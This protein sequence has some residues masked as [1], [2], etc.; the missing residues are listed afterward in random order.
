MSVRLAIAEADLSTLN[1][2]E[3]CRDH[4]ISR[5]RF[6]VLRRRFE[7]EG[8][9][10]L[11]ARS[12]APKRVANRTSAAIEDAIVAKRKELEDGGL[13]HGPATLWWHLS[14]E[15]GVEVV[16]SEATIWRVLVRRGFIDHDPTK[17]PNRRW[18]RFAAERA[19]ECWQLD[20]THWQLADNTP[21]EII[22][23]L[24]DCSRCAINSVAVVTCTAN[25]T[26]AA[27][28]DSAAVWGLPE[29]L[30]RDNAA[31]FKALDDALAGLG[32]QGRHSRPYHPQTCGKVE[33]FH[34]TLKKH[35]A[36]C[37]PYNSLEALQEALDR[38]CHTYNHHRPHRAHPRRATPHQ[39]WTDTPKAGPAGEPITAT[40]T[41]QVHHV[42]VNYG[43]VR[44][45]NYRIPLGQEHNHQ[46]ATVIATTCHVFIHRQLIRRLTLDPT[47][48]TQT[49]N[50]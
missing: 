4:G 39:I 27:L 1:V 10:G 19:N 34:L 8:L 43:R 40:V 36:A 29:R 23:I 6:Y 25:N 46:P 41:T 11:E 13:D 7:E 17:T 42:T 30:L 3:F 21:V 45:P 38:F 16:P 33:R 22:N 2:S 49:P 37:G 14:R 32:I 48:T 31:V 20:A 15:P 47:R 5:D 9:E 44:I 12:R 35:L 50:H 24:D 28:T 26:W 18:I